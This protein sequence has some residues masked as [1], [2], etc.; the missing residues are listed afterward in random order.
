MRLFFF[1]VV[2]A[3]SLNLYGQSK[4]I[5]ILDQTTHD[6]IDLVNVYYPR[7]SE[8][9]ITNEEGVL[10][11]A[12]RNDT[13]TF[14]HLNY[15]PL[16]LPDS[17]LKAIDTIYMNPIV[18]NLEEVVV[19]D[20]DLKKRLEKVAK[21]YGRLYLTDH[22]T[23]ETTYK[24][25]LKINNRLVRLI[26]VQLIWWQKSYNYDFAKG[27]YKQC[28]FSLKGIDFSKIPTEDAPLSDGGYLENDFMIP[29]F[30]L[31]YYFVYLFKYTV[32]IFIDEVLKLN[33][34]TK[35]V[36]TAPVVSNGKIAANLVKS[37]I[38]FDNESGAITYLKFNIQYPDKMTKEFSERRKVA[39]ESAITRLL[40]ELN[41]KQVQENKWLLA[42]FKSKI[43]GHFAYNGK[44]DTF[45][46][47]Q[48]L[49]VTKTTKGKKIDKSQKL[50]LKKPFY[51]N[52]PSGIPLENKILLTKEELDFINQK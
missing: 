28:A 24:E 39:Y 26:Q 19:Y 9:T 18:N 43:M 35:V 27:I 29:A 33:G 41:F 40:L 48:E 6:P 32:D 30:Y 37:E 31:N 5:T 23:N 45:E 7:L 42:S 52:F 4:K 46:M 16:K 2:L 15:A 21:L 34:S 12:T 51:E 25:I 14:S 22:N 3:I 49:Y 20:F 11:I 50:D 44:D 47:K 1:S 13:L 10:N 8:G 36:F 38:V 17:T